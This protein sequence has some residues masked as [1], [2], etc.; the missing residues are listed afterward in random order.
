MPERKKEGRRSFKLLDCIAYFAIMCIAVALVFRICFQQ[1]Q[2]NVA[3]AFRAIGECLAYILAIWM[4]FYW[5]RSHKHIGWFIGWLVATVLI[6][7]VYIFAM[8]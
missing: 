7:V 1:K 2:P 5:T 3:G 8:V 6:V 4:G